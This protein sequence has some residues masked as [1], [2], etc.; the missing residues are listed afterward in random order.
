ME[1]IIKTKE[2]LKGYTNIKAKQIWL[3]A[4]GNHLHIEEIFIS[5]LTGTQI[6]YS[7][8]DT[9]TGENLT[10]ENFTLCNLEEFKRFIKG[11]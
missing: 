2:D 4:C 1:K 8:Y 6:R 10:N 5:C 11:D 3:T 9:K 7:V